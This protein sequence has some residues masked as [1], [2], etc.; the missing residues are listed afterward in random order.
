MENLH[1]ILELLNILIPG[2]ILSI[3]IH[4]SGKKD[5][6]TSKTTACLIDLFSEY[7]STMSNINKALKESEKL[8]SCLEKGEFSSFNE[9]YYTEE[10]KNFREVGYFYELLGTMTRRNE[11]QEESVV[12]F[13]SFPIEFF[14]KTKKIRD[15]IRE[16]NYLPD[17][18]NNF[19]YLC[20]LYN[21][22]KKYTTGGW[23]VNGEIIV[24]SEA[25]MKELPP[26]NKK[27]VGFWRTAK[28]VIF[29][30]KAKKI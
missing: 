30:G 6:T 18:W 14:R 2:I 11:I 16:K 26:V 20:A 4:I 10:Y 21:A 24:L 17:Y 13:F 29:G 25:E 3:W 15:I 28:P 22:A 7:K 27:Q 12:H 5:S 19:C 23:V 9:F 1:I 8:Y